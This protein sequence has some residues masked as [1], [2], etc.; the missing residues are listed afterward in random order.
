M[1]SHYRF[2]PASEDAIIPWNA[3]Y[4]FPSVANKAV[5]ITPRIPPK[6]GSTFNP[7]DQ[8][9]L[10][11]PAQGY[12][13]PGMTTLEFDVALSGYDSST[14]GAFWAVWFQNSIHSIFRRIR[15]LYGSTTLEEILESGYLVRQITDLTS[16]ADNVLDQSTIAEG[17]GGYVGGFTVNGTYN[18]VAGDYGFSQRRTQH[19]VMQVGGTTTKAFPNWTTTNNVS[20][21][22][23]RYQISFPLGLFNQGKL[24]PVKFMA[25]QLAIELTLESVESCMMH[26][27]AINVA[28]PPVPTGAPTYQVR[29]VNMIPEILEFDS[30]Y[31]ELF[32]QGLQTQGVPVQFATWNTY[33][34]PVT[35]Q[36]MHI[37]IPERGR[38][39][40]AILGFIRKSAKSLV[41]D[42]GAS[43]GD[44]PGAFL[45]SYQFRIGGRYFPASPV[46]VNPTLN[47][48]SSASEPFT[49][50]QK[51]L[52]ILGDKRLATGTNHLTWNV[53]PETVTQTGFP[54]V[55]GAD[56]HQVHSILKLSSGI[57]DI[58]AAGYL[59]GVNALPKGSSNFCFAINLE[60][61]NG[62]EIS[63]M[64]GEEQSD[65]SLM[66]K[67]QNAPTTPTDWEFVIYT[68]V[69]RVMVLR[70]NNLVELTI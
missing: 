15:L 54:T 55:Y 22:V 31:D 1:A 49:E 70:E 40:K 16:T 12:V 4:E 56:D 42:A 66:V 9:R 39:I 51:A 46:I 17:S 48:K 65:I 21:A 45:E 30:S 2:Y 61:T 8:I 63:G 36:N 64:N 62:R 27:L 5:K 28:S 58:A 68:L 67:W 25:S 14:A 6:N 29:N 53:S 52:R 35:G 11:F 69:D 13:N 24:I 57:D 60:T 10:E 3:S 18:G 47:I 44:L 41:N 43:F 34:T 32:L 37:T 50:L 38:S 26:N 19:S 7:S 20:T 33:I 23:R 59:S